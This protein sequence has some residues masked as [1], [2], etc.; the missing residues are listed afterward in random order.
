VIGLALK[1][2]M[3][4]RVDVEDEVEG[5]DAAEHAET[6]YDFAGV[7]GGSRTVVGAGATVAS[8]RRE[9]VDA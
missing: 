6:A 1:A 8:Q 3:G 7:G 2:I 4:W 5:I 9:S